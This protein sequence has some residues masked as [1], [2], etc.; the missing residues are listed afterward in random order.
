MIDRAEP[1][2]VSGLKPESIYAKHIANMTVCWPTK[3]ALAPRL[4]ADILQQFKTLNVVPSKHDIQDLRA[5]P[6]PVIAKA[7]WENF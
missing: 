4:A 1:M 7:P 6:M 2:Q 3:L 5:W